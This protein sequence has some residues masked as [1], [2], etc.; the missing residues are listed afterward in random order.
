MTK[1]REWLLPIL[2]LVIFLAAYLATTLL[3][4]VLYLTEGGRDF[5][6]INLPNFSWSDFHRVFGA[7]FWLLLL[8]P[9]FFAPVA[10]AVGR[11]ASP[12]VERNIK[13]I[14]E[15]PLPA[16]LMLTG[17]LYSFVILALIKSNAVGMFL[18]AG[19]AVSA[20]ENRF[21]L[22]SR[23]GFLPQLFMKSLL[24]F[25][26]IYGAIQATRT[27]NRI[28]I[29]ITSLNVLLLTSCLILLNMKWPV[30]CFLLTLSICVFATATK[31]PYLKAAIVAS[32]SIITYFL[33]STII[34]R[35]FPTDGDKSSWTSTA[36]QSIKDRK[37][38]AF[39]KEMVRDVALGAITFGPRIALSAI[40][41]MALAAPY[42]FDFNS[43]SGSD[44]QPATWRLS[45]KRPIACEPTLLVYQKMFG[46]DGFAGRGTAPA[47]VTLSGYALA[48][49]TGAIISTITAMLFIGLFLALWP[50]AKSNSIVAAAFVMGSY[51]AYFLSQLPI[52]GPLLYDHGL[53]WVFLIITWLIIHRYAKELRRMATPVNFAIAAVMGLIAIGYLAVTLPSCAESNGLISI[54]GEQWPLTATGCGAAAQ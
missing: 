14:P 21:T 43:Y 54:F 39:G 31:R 37:G 2:P 6:A 1:F 44:C 8:L 49:W 46:D 35:W 18:S 24:V 20:V 38:I 3:G 27:E 40:N 5:P 11:A 15:F 42:Y 22:L 10:Y 32:L 48:G 50:A 45:I 29:L 23:L 36:E 52:E 12:I 53:W 47:S 30:V 9:F 7:E 25:L 26:S 41:R 4:N 19:D 16:F 13:H 34:L 51:T 28:W 17:A 33:L